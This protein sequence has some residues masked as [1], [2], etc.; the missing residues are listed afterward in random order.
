MRTAMSVD[1]EERLRCIERG[2]ESETVSFTQP[3]GE[4]RNSRIDRA[5]ADMLG[6]IE[7]YNDVGR[8]VKRGS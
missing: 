4:V 8:C 6:P 1:V 5:A 7:S 2:L 3:H